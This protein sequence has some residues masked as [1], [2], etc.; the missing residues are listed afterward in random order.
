MKKK[1]LAGAI[2]CIILVGTNVS[3]AVATNITEQNIKENLI[4]PNSIAPCFLVG[5]MHEKK[6]KIPW[7]FK[8]LWRPICI[9]RI[10]DTNGP[11]FLGPFSGIIEPGYYNYIGYVG[12][13]RFIRRPS[14]EGFFFICAE[15]TPFNF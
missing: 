2:L 4:D 8:S 3:M 1:I 11:H 13:L 6:V 7:G 5:I 15:M 10:G 14:G 12:G 9:I